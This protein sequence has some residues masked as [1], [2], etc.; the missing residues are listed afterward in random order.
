M[1][2]MRHFTHLCNW[3]QHTNKR[4]DMAKDSNNRRK[5]LTKQDIENLPGIKVGL[6][7]RTT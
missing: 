1:K 5:K 6:D 7:Y 3:N 2:K 4:K